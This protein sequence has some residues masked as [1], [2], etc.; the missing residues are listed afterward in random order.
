MSLGRLDVNAGVMA[1]AS[2]RAEPREGHLDRARRAVSYLVKSK[3]VT[4]RI[5]TEKPYLSSMHVTPCEWEESLCSK[6]TEFLPQDSPEPKQKHV[7]TVIYHDVNLCHNILT[8]RSVTG[9]IYFLNKTP[10]D[11]HSKK[12]ATVDT[13]T[14]GSEC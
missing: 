8:G 14:Y 7:V 11:W 4:I 13:A 5:R 2:F 3:H 1:L 10:M 6:V 12:Q 9:V